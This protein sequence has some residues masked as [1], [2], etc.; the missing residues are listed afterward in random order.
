MVD[1]AISLGETTHINRNSTGKPRKTLIQR[2]YFKGI[3]DRQ[4]ICFWKSCEGRQGWIEC[5]KG[6]EYPDMIDSVNYMSSSKRTMYFVPDETLMMI[7]EELGMRK[8]DTLS[9]TFK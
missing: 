4:F 6:L 5:S 1:H 7:K 8:T 3:F 9:I 2:G